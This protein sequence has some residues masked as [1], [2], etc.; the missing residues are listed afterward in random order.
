MS[1]DRTSISG[2]EEVIAYLQRDDVNASG[3]VNNLVKQHMNGGASEKQMLDFRIR[4]V[5]SEL[6]SLEGRAENKR[7]E[8]ERLEERRAD[9]MTD[10]EKNLE[11]AAEMFTRD[12]LHADNLAVQQQAKNAGMDIDEFIDGVEERLE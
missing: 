8:L 1:K 10:R 9:F 4:Q 6:E 11:E 12:Q 7:A 3:L 5:R 2:D